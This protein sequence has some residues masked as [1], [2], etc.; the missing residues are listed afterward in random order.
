M[1]AACESPDVVVVGDF[2]GTLDDFGGPRIGG[3]RDAAALR[4]DAALGT[5]PTAVPPLLAMPIDH[6]LLGSRGGAQLLGAHHPRTAPAPD[7]GRSSR[8]SPG[9]EPGGGFGAGSRSDNP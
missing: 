6:V 5:W 3:C 2:N 1:A 7:I 9:D 4:G 8:C